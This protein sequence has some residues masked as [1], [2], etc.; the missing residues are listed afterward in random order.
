M[1]G[2]NV[3]DGEMTEQERQLLLL[4]LL[5]NNSVSYF[6]ACRDIE[7]AI[8]LFSGRPKYEPS[9]MKWK[10]DLR[11]LGDYINGKLK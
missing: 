10:K 7:Q 4:Q 3:R 8:R 5:N 9:I 6:E 2:Y 1:L 11:F